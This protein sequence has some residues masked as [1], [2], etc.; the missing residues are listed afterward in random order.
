MPR[1]D[2]TGRA[3][4]RTMAPR[5]AGYCAGY[6]IPGY[7]NPYVGRPGLEYGF[8]NPITVSLMPY[9]R[10]APYRSYSARGRRSY[11]SY[12]RGRGRRRGRW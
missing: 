9:P 1:G 6:S 4:I 11:F 10:Y 5:A 12:G 8:A 2:G 7:M 3:G